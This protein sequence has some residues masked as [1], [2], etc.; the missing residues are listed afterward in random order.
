MVESLVEASFRRFVCGWLE[1]FVDN[2]DIPICLHNITTYVKHFS[3]LLTQLHRVCLGYIQT[4][5]TQRM[6]YSQP[7][8]EQTFY[9]RVSVKGGLILKD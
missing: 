1:N 6:S 5:I 2:M 7:L 9:N 8:H 3:T 4:Y